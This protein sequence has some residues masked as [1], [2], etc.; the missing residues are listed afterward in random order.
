VVADARGDACGS[1]A[2]LNHLIG[3]RLRQGIAVTEGGELP[4]CQP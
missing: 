1:G 2:P 4:E 3:I